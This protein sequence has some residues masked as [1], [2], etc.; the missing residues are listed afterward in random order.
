MARRRRGPHARPPTGGGHNPGG[1][2]PTGAGAPPP[3]PP[4]NPPNQAQGYAN[5]GIQLWKAVATFSHLVVLSIVVGV[6]LDMILIA[7]LS[8]WALIF[9]PLMPF[10]VFFAFQKAL[11]KQKHE[12]NELESSPQAKTAYDADQIKSLFQ[13]ATSADSPYGPTKVGRNE[14]PVYED[15]FGAPGLD[16]ADDAVKVGTEADTVVRIGRDYYA[17]MPKTWAFIGRV[18]TGEFTVTRNMTIDPGGI[19][20]QISV[21]LTLR[22]ARP[23]TGS[24]IWRLQHGDLDGGTLSDVFSMFQGQ[25][26]TWLASQRD[27]P[28]I[29]DGRQSFSD[30]WNR[31]KEGALESV[32]ETINTIDNVGRFALEIVAASGVDVEDDI[33]DAA[34]RTRTTAQAEAEGRSVGQAAGV[35]G[36]LT[37][38]EAMGNLTGL[39]G[40]LG[41][42]LSPTIHIHNDGGNGNNGNGGGNTNNGNNNP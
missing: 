27:R 39:A 1:A 24:T 37:D 11:G 3:P 42:L 20:L 13:P 10:V 17:T 41:G 6:V 7:A 36:V 16:A 30:Y 40:A 26:Q 28:A 5:F 33:E 31:N 38:S 34:V 23:L 2:A 25:V 21:Q 12:A 8:A 29:A 14:L 9:L 15:V 35:R 32:L 18:N 4:G 22:L 19:N